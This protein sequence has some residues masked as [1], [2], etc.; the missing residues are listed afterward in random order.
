MKE[1]V[2]ATHFSA[3]SSLGMRTNTP[4][5]PYTTEGTAASRST[6]IDNGPR[7]RSGHSS[8]RNR[9]VATAIGTP[10]ISAIAEVTIVPNSKGAPWNVSRETSQSL[11]NTKLRPNL[12][13]ASFDSPIR[14]MKKYASR[15]RMAAERTVS[16]TCMIWS[17][18][19]LPDD[20]SRAERPPGTGGALA[21]TTRPYERGEP[22]HVNRASRLLTFA[23]N[24]VGSG[25]Y[26]SWSEPAPSVC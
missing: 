21:S 16:P 4:H 22:L 24:D 12:L 15:T 17:G 9:A 20:R 2:L 10:M 7:A 19:R 3:G 5:R 14:R 13:S 8:V 18:N 11:P 26:G 25:A 1:N 23:A 6:S